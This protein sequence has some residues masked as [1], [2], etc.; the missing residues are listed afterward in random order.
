MSKLA[1]RIGIWASISQTA[2][3]YG[4]LIVYVIFM[5]LFPV[6]PWTTIQAF[7]ADINTPYM[8]WLTAIQV[9]AF[10]QAL[11]VL[12]I[13]ITL[14]DFSKPD[15]KILTRLAMAFALAFAIISC[16]HY[17]VQWTG[18][19]QSILRN[20]LEGLGLFVQFNFDSPMSTINMLGW[21]F[22]YGLT[23][24]SLAPLFKN[25]GIEQWIHWSF[26]INGIGCILCALILVMG[27][28]WIYLVWTGLISITWVAYPLLVT[29]F[30]RVQIATDNNK[31][32]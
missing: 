25:K 23:T 11:L 13:S 30:K 10:L 14:H 5:I 12:V 8:A 6:K 28:K 18:V 22:F 19:R 16:I 2:V 9:L 4:Y 3:G 7:A 20:D 1:T 17:Y 27:Q 31:A 24:L 26:L 21:M 29:V 32:V 15:Q